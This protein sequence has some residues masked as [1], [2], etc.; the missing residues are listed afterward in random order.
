M[1]SSQLIVSFTEIKNAQKIAGVLAFLA[2]VVCVPE[3][4]Q[5]ITHITA[6]MITLLGKNMSI[7][8]CFL[9][10]HL[11]FPVIPLSFPFCSFPFQLVCACMCAHVLPGTVWILKAEK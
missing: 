2:D 1:F 5:H 10:E 7:W 8:R 3:R 6:L 4:A 9:V 11:V